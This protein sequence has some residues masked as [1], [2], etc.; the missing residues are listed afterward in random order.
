[1]DDNFKEPNDDSNYEVEDIIGM[2][3]EDAY[4]HA[5][6][7]GFDYR[8]VQKDGVS[9]IITCDYRLDRMNFVVEN[10]IVV[11]CSFG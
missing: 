9:F 1:M 8:I 11:E 2:T 6:K 4:V 10:D 7:G 3:L 5:K